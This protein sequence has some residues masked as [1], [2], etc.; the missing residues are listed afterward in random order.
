M[1]DPMPTPRELEALKVLWS[2]GPSTVRD[3]Y[4]QLR[5]EHGDLAYTTILSLMQTMERKGLVGREETGKGKTHRYHARARNERTLRQLAG[6]F[7]DTVFDGAMSQYLVR[8]IE[9]RRPSIHELEEME[10]MVAEAKARA[11]EKGKGREGGR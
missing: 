11:Q 3:I 6:T 8:A 10:R 1:T 7:L 9:A 4:R 5:P 2:R